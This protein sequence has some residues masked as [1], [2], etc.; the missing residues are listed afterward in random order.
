MLTKIESSHPFLALSL[1]SFLFGL[2]Y[3]PSLGYLWYSVS[4]LSVFIQRT[5]GVRLS[6][7]F[8]C[9]FI[10]VICFVPLDAYVQIY[11]AFAVGD[12]LLVLSFG[13]LAV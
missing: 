10:M 7:L 1:L 5:L 12:H 4:A 6:S 2:H 3:G 9:D 8:L 11:T 13:G